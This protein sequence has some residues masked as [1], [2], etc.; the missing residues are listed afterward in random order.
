LLQN[1]QHVTATPQFL[2]AEYLICGV[3]IACLFRKNIATAYRAGKIPIEDNIHIFS[4][5]K[6]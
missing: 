1:L 3:K 4:W 5:N 6:R 2:V